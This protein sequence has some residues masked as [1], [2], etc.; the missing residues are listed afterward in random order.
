M[1]LGVCVSDASGAFHV[2]LGVPPDLQVGDYRLLVLTPGDSRYAAT[3]A[4]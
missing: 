4:P 3:V 2:S 1:L